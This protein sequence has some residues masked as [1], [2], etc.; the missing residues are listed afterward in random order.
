MNYVKLNTRSGSKSSKHTFIIV[1]AAVL[2]CVFVIAISHFSNPA[3]SLPFKL[4]SSVTN[5][6]GSQGSAKS[7][8]SDRFK[9]AVLHQSSSDVK[10][11]TGQGQI[12]GKVLES[13]EGR[14]Y[15]AFYDV[16]YAKPPVGELRFKVGL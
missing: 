2:S 9:P 3:A 15:F 12:L 4:E 14:K 5:G 6:D 11:S 16:P 13:R 10:L 8:D 1:T 7:D